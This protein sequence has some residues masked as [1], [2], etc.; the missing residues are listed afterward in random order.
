M[1]GTDTDQVGYLITTEWG[2]PPVTT[3]LD[4]YKV[5]N[6]YPYVFQPSTHSPPSD[7]S[8][9]VA[10][11]QTEWTAEVALLA[12]R[13]AYL[14]GQYVNESPVNPTYGLSPADDRDFVEAP[15]LKVDEV[16]LEETPK[17]EAPA[18]KAEV[19]VVDK[20]EPK[21]VEVAPAKAEVKPEPKVE[22]IEHKVEAKPVEAKPESRQQVVVEPKPAEIKAE[23]ENKEV[24]GN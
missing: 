20:P 14:A 17:V 23:S 24:E 7:Y 4:S 10:Q 22:D 19:Q 3:G 8:T 18:P 2:G 6:V 15:D 11:Q 16:E 1:A 5:A 21:P 13:P 9:D 12:S